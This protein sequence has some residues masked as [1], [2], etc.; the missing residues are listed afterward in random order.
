[1]NR[2]LLQRCQKFGQAYINDAVF[3]KTWE[4]NLQHLRAV[5]Y[6]K[7]GLLTFKLPKCQF[8]LKEVKHL[9]HIIGEGQLRPDPEKL[10]AIQSYPKS[11]TKSQVNSFI[12]LVSYALPQVCT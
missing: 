8:G 3:S 9:G 5:L 10:D 7:Q 6:S 11:V 2:V 12:G 1:M 4:E